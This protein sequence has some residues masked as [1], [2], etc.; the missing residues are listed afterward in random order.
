MVDIRD[1]EKVLVVLV[2]VFT[3]VLGN[4]VHLLPPSVVMKAPTGKFGLV[5]MMKVVVPKPRKGDSSRPFPSVL[6]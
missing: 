3:S 4:A 6:C 1:V 2:C 5:D